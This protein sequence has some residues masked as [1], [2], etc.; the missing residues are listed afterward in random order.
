[1]KEASRLHTLAEPS[2]AGAAAPTRPRRLARLVLPLLVLGAAALLLAYAA[3]A[4]FEKGREVEVAPVIP[5]A[6]GAGATQ[7]PETQPDR[8]RRAGFVV[9]APGWLEPD[10]YAVVVPALAEG[11]VASVHALEGERVEAGQVLAR[12][13]DDDAKLLAAGAEASLSGALAEV[14]RAAAV[15]GAAEAQALLERAAV[16]E[17]ADEVDRKRDLIEVGGVSA[18]EFR[19]LEIRLGGF[20]ARALAAERS[21]DEARAMLSQAEAMVVAA[22]VARDEAEL[23]LARMAIVSPS[24]GV[25]LARYIEPGMRI[26]MSARDADAG[27]MSGAVMRLYDP[28]RLQARVDVPLADAAKVALGWHAVVTTEAVPDAAFSGVVARLVHEANI[29]RN[30][31]QFKVPIIDPSPVLKPGMLVRVR[32]TPPAN[33]EESA[34]AP[35]LGASG[36]MRLLVPARAAALLEGDRRAVWTVESRAGALR[37]SRRE[38]TVAASERGEYLAVVSGLVLTDRVVIDPPPTLREGERLVIRA[39]GASSGAGSP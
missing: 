4:S 38:V 14:E 26:S 31:V 3:R 32:L 7:G 25:V 24:D 29:Q 5:V 22:R 20:K 39:A 17:L 12:L 28:A 6:D 34:G 15:L 21:V 36:G 9:Q 35:G 10:P 13:V 11:V 33:S 37:A 27:P 30:T 8:G 19:R 1:M 16:D 2:R 23:C 18:G